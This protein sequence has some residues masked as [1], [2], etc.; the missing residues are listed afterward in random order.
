VV[1]PEIT[2]RSGCAEWCNGLVTLSDADV[3]D[4]A[5][6]AVDRRDID[7]DIEII[8]SD[9]VDP[10]RWST[11]A[12]TVRAGGAQSYVTA[13]MSHEEALAKLIA[14]LAGP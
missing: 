7:L 1:L 2:T 4:L 3:A 14:D 10:Y 6:E 8:P 11:P 13:D 12:W 9:P 5:R